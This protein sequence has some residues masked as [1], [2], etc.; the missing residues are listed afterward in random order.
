MN[1]RLRALYTD[2]LCQPYLVESD[3][4][5]THQTKSVSLPLTARNIKVVVQKDIVFGNWRDAYTFSMNTTKLCLRI[6]GV[7]LSSKIQP[8]E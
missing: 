1:T 3:T 2:S 4:L 8:C 7:T 5:W 6:T